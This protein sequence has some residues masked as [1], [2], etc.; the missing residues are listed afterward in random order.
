VHW[1][2]DGAQCLAV[3]SA[4]QEF[5][6]AFAEA[7]RSEADT[8]K[9]EALRL[10]DDAESHLRTAEKL[11]EHALELEVR[12]RELDEMLGRSSQLALPVTQNFLGGEGLRLKAVEVL[13]STRGPGFPIHYKEWFEL[14]MNAGYRVHGQDPIATFL[15]QITRSP[16]ITSAAP[17]RGVYV[18]DVEAAIARAATRLRAAESALVHA[19]AAV[20]ATEARLARSMGSI[21]STDDTKDEFA[22]ARREHRSAQREASEVAR[23]HSIVARVRHGEQAEVA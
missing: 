10:R 19:Q 6:S 9:V 14:L 21:R 22:G 7:A 2:R 5:S 3:A 15:S 16:V 12:A 11:S 20:N 1:P 4:T 13:A 18:L 23:A 17:N 8:L